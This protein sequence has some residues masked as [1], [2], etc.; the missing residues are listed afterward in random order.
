MVV[1]EEKDTKVEEDTSFLYVELLKRLEESA[2]KVVDKF[3]RSVEFEVPSTLWKSL[4]TMFKRMSNDI[5]KV[6]VNFPLDQLPSKKDFLVFHARE[7][8]VVKVDM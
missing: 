1:L 4:R 7:T 5:L 6:G 8:K 3:Q 2:N